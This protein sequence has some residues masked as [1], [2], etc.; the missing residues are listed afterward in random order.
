MTQNLFVVKSGDSAEEAIEHL[1]TIYGDDVKKDLDFKGKNV[2]IP[3]D[4]D[5]KKKDEVHKKIVEDLNAKHAVVHVGGQVYILYEFF[6]PVRGYQDV[7]FMNPS[8][9]KLKYQNHI[10]YY[11]DKNGIV[12]HTK[13]KAQLWLEHSKRREYECVTFHPGKLTGPKFNGVYNFWAGWAVNPDSK[14]SCNLYLDF[15]KEVICSGDL[16]AYNYLIRWLAQLVQQPVKKTGTTVVLKGAKGTGKNTLFRVM[17]RIAGKHGIQV[18]QPEHVL[19]RFNGHLKD[20]VL[21][22]CNEAFLGGTAKKVEGALK[23]LITEENLAIEQKFQPALQ[24]PNYT[25]LVLLSNEDWVVPASLDERRFFVLNVSDCKRG[26]R[27]YWDALHKEIDQEN[28]AGAFLHFLQNL[29]L[30]GWDMRTVPETEG[31]AEQKLQSL[32]LVERFIYESLQEGSLLQ[33]AKWWGPTPRDF[34]YG[35]F[36]AF[37]K[38]KTRRIPARSDF[39]KKV[40]KLITWDDGRPTWKKLKGMG[41]PTG[42]TGKESQVRTWEPL[43]LDESRR[44]FETVLGHSVEW[45]S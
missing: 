7:S 31:L 25:R 41:Y 11:E 12:I 19:G 30:T 38:G 23:N 24:V 3:K 44:E 14:S 29:D 27:E 13:T 33:T 4:A 34:V 32:D 28:A 42:G 22:I 36:E 35:A 21:V 26:D 39:A 20:K 15:I 8:D 18:T 9:F 17:E 43:S 10:I 45:D 37:C 16:E 2:V 5:D 40:R 1:K 6:D